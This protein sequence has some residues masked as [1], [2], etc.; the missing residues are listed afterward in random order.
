MLRIAHI[1]DLHVLSPL[2]AEWRRA[3]FNK[4]MTGYA[5]VLLGRGRVYRPHYLAAV[6]AEVQQRADHVV[7]TGDITNLALESEYDQARRLLDQIA[8]RTEVTV[9]PGNHDLYL[10]EVGRERR[11]TRHFE[12]FVASDLEELAVEVPAGHFPRVK[13]RGPAAFVS[14]STAVPR[15]P[16]VSA[17]VLGRAQLTALRSVLEHPEVRA[18]TPVILLHHDPLDGRLRIEQLRGGLIDAPALRE[19]LSG[20]GGG[21][22][23]FGHL[24]LR[25]RRRLQTAAGSLEVVSA[26]G[27]SLDH[28]SDRVRAGYNLYTLADSGAVTSIEAWVL[29][30][31]SMSFTRAALALDGATA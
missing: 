20:L 23:L 21:L 9:V 30:P 15:P 27:A 10:P 4:R 3:V 17:G 2:G 1:S 26:S 5:N 14:L 7:V 16:F 12:P 6:L 29:D 31:A 19:A 24:H 8:V 22:V 11:F 18:R 25:R 28:P 13:L